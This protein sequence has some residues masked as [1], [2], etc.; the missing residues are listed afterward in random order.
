MAKFCVKRPFTVLVAVIMVLVLGFVSLTGMQTDLLPDFSLPYLL[1]ITTYPGASPEKVESSVTEPLEGALGTISGVE[2]VTSTSAENYSMVMLEFSENMNMDS[3]MVKVSTAID[4]VEPYLPELCSTPSIMEISMNM[5]ATMYVSVSWDDESMDIYDVSDFTEET[6]VPYL[7]RQTGVA[8]ISDIGLV[9]QTVEI[10]LNQDKV[11]EVNDRLLTQVSQRLAEAK[12]KLDD[13]QAELDKAQ[14]ELESNQSSVSDGLA[15]ATEALTQLSSYQTQLTNQQAQLAALQMARETAAEQLAENGVDVDS[16][17][18]NISTLNSTISALNLVY[19]ALNAMGISDDTSLVEVGEILSQIEAELPESTQI[20]LGTLLT[21]Q[22]TTVGGIAEYAATLQEALDGLRTAKTTLDQFDTEITNLTVEIQVTQEIVKQ[23]QAALGSASYSQVTSGS[24]SAA[25]GFGSADAQLA[26]AQAQ[27]DAAVEEYESAREEALQSANLDSLLNLDTLSSLIYAQN[28]SMPAGYI[29]AE[30]DDQWLLKIGEEFESV[31]ELENML[32]C[33]MDGIG[34]VRISDVAD[35]TVIDNTGEAYA[36]MN[37]GDAVVLSIFKG[38]TYGTSSVSKA[39]NR[40]IEELQEEY[41]GLRITVLMDQGDYIQMIVQSIFRN[42]IEGALLAVVVLALFLKDPKPT[43][44][45]AFSIPFSVLFAIVMMYFSDISLNILSMSGLALG[46]GMLV[47]NSVVVVE[48]IYRLRARGVPIGRAA[49]QGTKQVTGA[50]VASTLTT[51]CVFLPLLFS[52]GL[53]RELISDMGL[54][55]AFSLIASLIVAL[56]VVPTMSVSLLKRSEPKSHRLFDKMLNGYEV[57]LRFCLRQKWV[58]LTISV[59]LL[60]VSVVAVTRIGIVVLPDIGSNQVQVDVVMPKEL[61]RDEAYQRAD[62]VM[63][64]ILELDGI[65]C[66]GGMTSSTT[67][68]LVTSSAGALGDYSSYLY[69]IMLEDDANADQV[70]KAIEEATADIDC[71]LTASTAASMDMSSMLSSGLSVD[72]RGRDLDDLIQASEDVMAIVENIEG[73]TDVSNGQEEGD[74]IVQL[75][76]DKDKAMGYGLTVAQIYSELASAMTTETSSTTVTVDHTDMNVTVVNENDPIALDNLLDYEFEV[77]TTDEDGNSVDE[78]ITLGDIAT[79]S[80]GK[81]VASI[82]RENQTR[83]IS[84]TASTE[85]GYNTTLL[86]RQVSKALEDY[87]P[88]EGVTITLG[89]ETSTVNEMLIQMVKMITLAVLFVYLIMVA[90]FQ[91]L[92]APFIVLF[93]MPLAFTG[94]MIGLILTRQQLSLVSLIGF[95]VLVGVIV[96]NGIV[97]VDYV[98]QLRKGGLD[99]IN[100]LVATGRTRMRPIL[101]TALTTIFAMTMMILSTDAGSQMGRGMAIVVV[102]GL[103]YGTLMTLYIIPVMYDL[104]FRKKVTEV[105]VGEDDLDELPDDAAEFIAQYQSVEK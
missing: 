85:E 100:A 41:P 1:V 20:S 84:V 104:F 44:V 35:V 86:S 69:Y 48:N 5:V 77:T 68:S 11:D 46:I 67:A 66:V 55:I 74:T 32:L 38:S 3:A 61:D 62:E 52:E 33:S 30:D 91:S 2:N 82:S 10:R 28:F 22:I 96:N 17:D 87:E 18:D 40:A 72:L 54:T 27:M 78:T 58:P 6:V 42:L 64:R 92:L 21:E 12:T 23:Y 50:I 93:T 75:N 89:G 83:T 70:C 51:I 56:T 65:D 59:G 60:V 47:D 8:N 34:D 76:I 19:S 80:Y 73:F 90:Q 15:A 57:S 105:D 98:N 37:G 4:S 39:C 99:R 103:L 16:L 24:I 7:E 79:V 14:A 36:K 45:V 94:G 101:M 88:P 9:E 13:A 95:L 102:G 43:L 97:F 63:D 26:S 25:A 53:V 29:D 31:E 71:E 81:G 49:V